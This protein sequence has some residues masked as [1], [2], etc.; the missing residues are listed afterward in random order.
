M[1]LTKTQIEKYAD[2]LIWALESARTGKYKAYDTILIRFDLEALPL[3]E[4]LHE[5]LVKN[6]M[7]PSLRLSGWPA[8]ERNFFLY[9]DGK[10]RK[11]FN[12]GEKEFY[13]ALN[14]NIFL[15]APASL[16]HLKDIDP[17]KISEVMISRKPFRDILDIRESKGHFGW[18][19]CTVPTPALAEKAKL[20]EKEYTAQVVK[21]CFLDEK[22]PVKKWMEIFKNSVEIKKWLNSIPAKTLH[23]SSPRTDLAISLGEK[24]RFIGVSG[25]NIPS[26]EIFVSPDWRGTSGVYFA[27][28]PSYRTGNYVKDVKLVFKNGRVVKISAKEGEDF[29]RKMLNTD[30]GACQVGEFSLTDKRFSKID[31]FMADTL[32]DEN[33]GGKSGNCHIALGSS[34]S[35]TYSG[36]TENLKGTL[37]KKLGFN[38]SALHW[39]LV[40]TEAKTVT[41]ELKNGRRRVL[42]ENGMFRY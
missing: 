22:D 39:D 36:N 18:T 42:Y 6:K 10:Q 3:A 1:P 19:L 5:R 15:S 30:R 2:V 32:Y 16:T 33:Y 25:H 11:F 9:S 23:I 41:A 17:K 8:V 12:A 37:K 35:E 40:N 7:N 38:E 24:R 4:A 28:Q 34:Y 27:D 31:R 14:G 29:T 21:A 26:F 20:S 13:G